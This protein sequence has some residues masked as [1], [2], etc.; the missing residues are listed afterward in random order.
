MT[1]LELAQSNSAQA[2]LKKAL[3]RIS[4]CRCA[5]VAELYRHHHALSRRLKQKQPIEHSLVKLNKN[6]QC[7]LEK[8]EQIEKCFPKIEFPQELPVSQKTDELAQLILKH[9]VV[10]LAGET[11]SGKT[12]QLPKLCLKIGRGRRGL[13]GHTQPRRIAARAVASRI[14][15]ELKVNL[16]EQVGYKIRF[17]DLTNIQNHSTQDPQNVQ[18]SKN[19]QSFQTQKAKTSIQVMTDGILLAEMSTDPELSQY[20]TLIIDEAHERSLNIDFIL[21]YLKELLKKRTDLKIIITSATIDLQRFSKHFNNAPILEVSGR[22]YPVE[23]RYRPLVSELDDSKLEPL[24]ALA[25]ATEELMSDGAGDILVFLAGEREIRESSEFL[26]KKFTSKVEL[27]PLYSRLNRSEQDKVFKPHSKRRIVLA[28]NVAETSLTVPNIRY[29]IDFGLARISRYSQRTKVQRLPIEPISQA[30]AEQ[31]KGRCGRTANG[32]CIRLYAEDDFQ[33]RPVFTDPEIHRTNLAAVILKMLNMRLGD[34]EQFP[35]IEPPESKQISDGYRLLQ[36]LQAI[37]EKKQIT[38]MGNKMARLPVDPRQARMLIEATKYHCLKEL[39][40]ITSAMSV[41]DLRERPMEKRQAADEWHLR[42]NQQPSDFM[43]LINI[44]NY[45]HQLKSDLS[46]SQ[47]RKRL[48]SEFLSYIRLRDWQD[49]YRQLD[50]VF[51]DTYF[52]EKQVKEKQTKNVIGGSYPVKTHNKISQQ[53]G[54]Y[55]S[56]HKAVISGLPDQIGNKTSEGDYQGARQS[57]FVVQRQSASNKQSKNTLALIDKE[58]DPATETTLLQGKGLHDKAQ[59]KTESPGK[60]WIVVSELIET[61]RLFASTV[62]N[63]D[64]SWVIEVVPHLITTKYFEP[65]WKQKTGHVVANMQKTL[66]GMLLVANQQVSYEKIDP[67]FCRQCFLEHGILQRQFKTRISEIHHFWQ[68]LDKVIEQ[69][70]KIRRRDRLLDTE[71]LLTLLDEKI[72][73]GIMSVSSLERWYKKAHKSE[74]SKLL[75]KEEELLKTDVKTMPKLPEFWEL[76]EMKLPMSYRFEPGHDDDGV[77]IKVPLTLLTNLKVADFEYLIPYL[78]RDKIIALIK[79]LPKKLRK[80]FIPAPD[81]A[82][83]LLERMDSQKTSVERLHQFMARNLQQMTGALISPD[84]FD[85]IELPNHLT[86]LFNVVNARGQSLAKGR[87]LLQLQQQANDKNWKSGPLPQKTQSTFEQK[88]GLTDWPEERINQVVET[89]QAGVKIKQWPALIDEGK[90]VGIRL[91]ESHEKAEYYSRNGL[92]KL[93]YLQLSDKSR[94]LSKNLPDKNS[95]S[96]LYASLGRWEQLLEELV[97]HVIKRY[98]SDITNASLPQ[99]RQDFHRL[100]EQF[101]PNIIAD[102]TE[103]SKTIN[104]LLVQWSKIRSAVKKSL[105]ATALA[106]FRDIQIQLDALIYKGFIGN[107]TDEM[108]GNYSRYFKALRLRIDKLPHTSNKE[109]QYLEILQSWSKKLSSLQEMIQPWSPLWNDYQKLLWMLSE[110]RVSLFTQEIGTPWPISEKRLQKQF[111]VLKAQL[112]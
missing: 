4:Q 27:L 83:A 62:A 1:E 21:G 107:V 51:K 78:L 96:L 55:A 28:T 72:P 104:Q 91:Q 7:S 30:S 98:L 35:F 22:T 49:T 69:E 54:D 76:G 6:I 43:A 73:V 34:I 102:V 59:V 80:Q 2:L 52:K 20:D 87:S 79:G 23:T 15:Q 90:T 31:R 12:T 64:T 68:S 97:L 39:L 105:T 24:D 36:T 53:Y 74:K 3:K 42:F 58:L 57:R 11:G 112:V 18:N 67:V 103:F 46:S 25:L 47:Y 86:L 99:K 65:H 45:V 95:L 92:L 13:I 48:K 94:Y 89:S 110:L 88:K 75:V 60:E 82:D 33:S 38:P 106:S 40:I 56:I 8:I 50:R 16:G 26:K 71:Q 93:I 111:D 100:V 66:F 108:L 85:D 32:I 41:Q 17:D 9:Q 77:T 81:F 109:R 19:R 29:V 10:I 84:E 70:N 61:N 5:D 44:W 14:S 63:I 37:D 101:A